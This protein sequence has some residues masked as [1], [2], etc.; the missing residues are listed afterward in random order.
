[1]NGKILIPF[2]ASAEVAIEGYEITMVLR[3]GEIIVT[4]QENQ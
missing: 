2:I 1:M 4:I 3:D